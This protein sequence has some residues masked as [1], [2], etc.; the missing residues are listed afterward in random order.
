VKLKKTEKAKCRH[1]GE[2]IDDETE[3]DG[4]CDFCAEEQ[5]FDEGYE[6]EW[7]EV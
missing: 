7:I 2:P 1:C 4:L 6:E 5:S 3:N